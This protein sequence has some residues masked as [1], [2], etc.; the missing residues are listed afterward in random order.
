MPPPE[1]TGTVTHEGIEDVTY[2]LTYHG[3]E[4]VPERE[5]PV[6]DPAQTSAVHTFLSDNWPY[7]LTGAAMILALSFGGLMLYYRKEAKC[8][9]TAYAVD[10]EIDTEQE[11]TP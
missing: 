1:Y 4:I 2:V 5:K 7:L 3:C 11:E 9:E 6:D 8:R 10:A